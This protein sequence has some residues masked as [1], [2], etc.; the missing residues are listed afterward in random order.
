M[1]PRTACPC[2]PQSPQS[3]LTPKQPTL[4][5]RLR[6]SRTGVRLVSV[7]ADLDSVV[8]VDIILYLG[9]QASL[10]RNKGVNSVN[11]RPRLDPVIASDRETDPRDAPPTDKT[12][13]P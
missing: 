2:R 8:A 10:V 11:M 5:K 6:E 1:T 9:L 12:D 13:P 7:T 4:H 3:T